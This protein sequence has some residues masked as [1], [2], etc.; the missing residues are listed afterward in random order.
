MRCTA[1]AFG[2]T[3]NDL[4][5]TEDVNRSTGEVQVDVQFRIGKLPIVRHLEDVINLF[6]SEHLGLQAR[7]AFDTGQGTQH[8]LESAQADDIYI[9]SG[10]LSPDEVRIRLG[11]RISRERPTP[12]FIDNNRNGPIPLLAV[13]SLSGKID[14]TTYGPDQSQVLLDHPFI[15]AP[16]A[17]PVTGSAQAREALN[18]ASNMQDNMLIQNNDQQAPNTSRHSVHMM[19]DIAEAAGPEESDVVKEAFE[20]I[21][22]LLDRLAKKDG[23]IG[24]VDNTGGPGVTRGFSGTAG[25]TAS[26]G[27]Q[28]VD[29]IGRKKKKKAKT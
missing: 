20:I 9:K 4:G 10:V 17:A 6:I 25:I 5:F 2:V 13:E 24:G 22:L 21:D 26:T 29:L 19:Q 27:A 16:G 18:A 14:A 8:R 15:P 23:M 28:G 1:A 12:R 7:I 3:P 11:K